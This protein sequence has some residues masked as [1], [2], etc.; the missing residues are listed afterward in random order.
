M[1]MVRQLPLSSCG[2]L[3]PFWWPCAVLMPSDKD[4]SRCCSH[5]SHW[6]S[7]MWPDVHC[8]HAGI[9]AQAP[10]PTSCAWAICARL[11]LP[12]LPNARSMEVRGFARRP[13]SASRLEPVTDTVLFSSVRVSSL[14]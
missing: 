9:P 12:L 6:Q 11:K 5:S 7:H 10:R 4:I 1:Q 3:H 8:P 14:P 13:K 2:E